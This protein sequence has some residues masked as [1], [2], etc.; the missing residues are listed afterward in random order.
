MR[1]CLKSQFQVY[2]D[3][4]LMLLTD[5]EIR[6]PQ[7]SLYQRAAGRI[8]KYLFKIPFERGEAPPG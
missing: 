3:R 1:Q 7:A 4:F 6:F 8:T 2:H 5:Q